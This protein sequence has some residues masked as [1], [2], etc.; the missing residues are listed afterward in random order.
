MPSNIQLAAAE[1]DAEHENLG[2]DR[3]ERDAAVNVVMRLRLKCDRL[4][5]MLDEALERESRLIENL[6]SVLK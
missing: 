6:R 1:I 5:E 3:P 2:N 4:R